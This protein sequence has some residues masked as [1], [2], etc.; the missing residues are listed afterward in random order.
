MVSK[1]KLKQLFAF[2]DARKAHLENAMLP[3]AVKYRLIVEARQVER[4]IIDLCK[5]CMKAEDELK[6]LKEGEKV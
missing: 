2:I 3:D 6:K 5:D 4:T 1:D